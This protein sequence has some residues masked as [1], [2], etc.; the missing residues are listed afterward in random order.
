MKFLLFLLFCVINYIVGSINGALV[1]GKVFYNVD[2]REHGSGNLGA[3]NAGRVLGK[4]VSIIVTVIDALK[5]AVLFFIFSIFDYNLALFASVFSAV[6]HCYPLFAN[7][8]GGKAVATTM[9]IVFAISLLSLKE[10]V[11]VFLIPLILWLTIKKLTDLVSLAS[12][13]CVLISAVLSTFA[14]D[15]Y[16]TIVI[17]LLWVLLAYRHKENI[18]R[19]IEGTEN[20]ANY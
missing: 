3:T 5:G 20:K 9:G 16:K 1:I 2:I 17:T 19:L 12:I 15:V 13:F 7:F 6:G 8:K 18:V 4:K 14:C 10:F 11:L